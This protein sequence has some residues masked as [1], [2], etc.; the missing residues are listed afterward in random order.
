MK[1]LSG[2]Y[3]NGQTIKTNIKLTSAR[4]LCVFHLHLLFFL[5]ESKIGNVLGHGMVL[6]CIKKWNRVFSAL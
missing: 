2:M 1:S 5:D 6:H 4:V 3:K